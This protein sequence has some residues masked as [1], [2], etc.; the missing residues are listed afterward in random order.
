[1]AGG[2]P[3][4]SP[5]PAIPAGPHLCTSPPS[6]AGRYL[7]P[8]DPDLAWLRDVEHLRALPQRYSR[9]IDERDAP[10][11]YGDDLQSGLIGIDT[12]DV[13]P[14][15]DGGLPPVGKRG[16]APLGDLQRIGRRNELVPAEHRPRPR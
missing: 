10:L 7:M 3:E 12:G 16:A 8:L 2:T 5:P 11:R 1:M 13:H 4:G 9:A 15:V 6:M 14:E